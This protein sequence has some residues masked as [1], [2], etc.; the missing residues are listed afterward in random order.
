MDE[1]GIFQGKPTNWDD[2]WGFCDRNCPIHAI[3][4]RAGWRKDKTVKM[5]LQYYNSALWT[6]LELYGIILPWII[7]LGLILTTGLPIA[8]KQTVQSHFTMNLKNLKLVT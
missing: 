2:P 1:D 6:G 7:I 8:G 4:E 3:H 5:T